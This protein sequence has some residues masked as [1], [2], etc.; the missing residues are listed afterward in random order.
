[1]RI[2]ESH[3]FRSLAGLVVLSTAVIAV[4]AILQLGYGAYPIGWCEILSALFHPSAV[5]E[6]IVAVVRNL[7]LPRVLV[8]IFVGVNLSFAGAVFQSVTRNDMASP[9][10]L[11]VSQGAGLVILVVLV[12]LPAFTPML[13]LLAMLGG[14]AAFLIVYAVAWDHGTSPVRLILAGIIVGAIA[15][16]AHTLL[17]FFAPDV[18]TTQNAV[19]WT[20]GSLTGTSW[21]NVWRVAPWTVV[22]VAVILLGSRHLDLM[23]LGENTAKALG[24]P[25]ERMRFILAAAAI[26]ASSSSV[27]AA[28][29]VGFIGLVV[30]HCVRAVVGSRNLPVLIGC[31]FAGPALLLASDTVAR[32]AFSPVQ[33]PVGVVT[34]VMGGLFFLHLMRRRMRQ[35]GRE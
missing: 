20:A 27:A 22:T 34:G 2:L 10:L 7:R 6:R 5:D 17:F 4:C 21:I 11:G 35:R 9:Y 1:M 18:H 28:G 12:L 32:L 16:S 3:P 13:P 31:L 23:Q 15:G 26:L 33:L 14:L 29:L 30:P 24:M 25:V 8:A 19:S